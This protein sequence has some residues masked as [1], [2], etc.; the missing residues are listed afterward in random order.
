MTG[1]T[2]LQEVLNSMQV[3]CDD[4]EYG[5]AVVEPTTLIAVSELLGTFNEP[6]GLTLIATKDYLEKMSITCEG[7]FAKLTIDIHTS[8]ELVGLTAV[9]ATKLAESEV[10]ANV[11]AAFYHDHVFVQYSLRQKAIDALHSLRN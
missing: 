2:N 3:S 9:L 11:V 10:S 7:P 1:Q 8:L 5:F 6:E 4:V